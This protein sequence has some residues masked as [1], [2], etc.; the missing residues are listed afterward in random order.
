MPP[1]YELCPHTQ[2]P[3]LLPLGDQPCPHCRRRH[4]RRELAA[5]STASTALHATAKE[6][7]SRI[8]ATRSTSTDEE[9]AADLQDR[10]IAVSDSI[11]ASEGIHITK[12]DVHGR[13]FGTT[14]HDP[15]ID[16]SSDLTSGSALVA[17]VRSQVPAM[18][19]SD[20]LEV[21]RILIR[22][23][24]AQSDGSGGPLWDEPCA[25]PQSDDA[26]CEAHRGDVACA[27]N[28]CR[29]RVHLLRIQIVRVPV[30]PR[31]STAWKSLCEG[32]RLAHADAAVA[33]AELW[34]A[35]EMKMRR[36]PLTQRAQLT[37]AI[38]ARL[39]ETFT[40]T[41]V[42]NEFRR[43]YRKAAVEVGFQAVYVVGSV[44]ELVSRIDT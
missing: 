24:N 1:N 27:A 12:Q 14:Q 20:S 22:H 13:I 2:R 41:D 17:Q 33:A 4:L 34:Q 3:I 23:L 43:I 30:G 5:N 15:V 21:G 25:M 8:V 7:G 44:T 40:F 38:N 28:P 37:L 11:T 32:A 10:S 29:N 42:V 6:D 16:A 39:F 9:S 18:N 26:D 31:A 35:I 19:E 36:Y